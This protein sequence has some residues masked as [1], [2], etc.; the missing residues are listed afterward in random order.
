MAIQFTPDGSGLAVGDEQTV[1]IWDGKTGRERFRF[2]SGG[3]ARDITFD[4]DGRRLAAAVAVGKGFREALVQVWD[5]PAG[6]LC[7]VTPCAPAGWSA[8][9]FSPDGR[10]VTMTFLGPASAPGRWPAFVRVLEASTG[11]EVRTMPLREVGIGQ[12]LE[13]IEFSPDGR[14]LLVCHA[15][16]D[17]HAS[18]ATVYDF[19]TGRELIAL[20]SPPGKN[21]FSGFTPDGRG[22]V[23]GPIDVPSFRVWDISRRD[24]PSRLGAIPEQAGLQGLEFDATG[25]RVAAATLYHGVRVWDVQTGRE[26]C[27]WGPPFHELGPVR[28]SLDGKLLLAVG[29]LRGNRDP[30]CG[31]WVLYDV[32]RRRVAREGPEGGGFI[33]DT[34]LGPAGRWFVTGSEPIIGQPETSGELALWDTTTGERL[35]QVEETP[36]G[37]WSVVVVSSDGS[38][39]AAILRHPRADGTG[40]LRTLKVW[41]VPG[42]HLLYSRTIS[43][44]SLVPRVCFSRDG[45]RL[46]VGADAHPVLVLDADTGGE[47]LNCDDVGQPLGFS[48][49]GRQLAAVGQVDASRRAV[50]RV[51]D[52][53]SGVTTYAEEFANPLRLALAPEWS[54]LAFGEERSR[55]V[56]TRE[57]GGE[58]GYR[59]VQ[60]SGGFSFG[61]AFDAA[62]R[63]VVGQGTGRARAW[64]PQS[65][66]EILGIDPAVP[67]YTAFTAVSP[68]RQFEARVEGGEVRLRRLT[69]PR[70]GEIVRQSAEAVRHHLE[71]EEV[72]RRDGNAFAAAFHRRQSAAVPTEDPVLCRRRG[73]LLAQNGEWAL[74]LPSLE[75]AAKAAET[76]GP[77][78]Y[79]LARCQLAAGDSEG[80]RRS[81]AALLALGTDKSTQA[82]AFDIAW[83]C[84][85]RPDSVED[86]RQVIAL[87]DRKE[88]R[89]GLTLGQHQILGALYSRAGEARAALRHLDEARR[90]NGGRANTYVALCLAI[91][92][93]RAGDQR[94]GRRWLGVA[95]G[96]M[97]RFKPGLR[98]A[99]LVG[100]GA[101]G[102]LAAAPAST[103]DPPEALGRGDWGPRQ[104]LE[105]T[106]LRREAEAM[107][108]GALIHR[109][110][111]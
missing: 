44:Q 29:Q 98:A 6:R 103:V 94:E 41:D 26:V 10:L 75:H 17:W 99:A 11:Q 23:G 7:F 4:P 16:G 19:T 107:L 83:T 36:R 25:G 62:G 38:R 84:A 31:K 49:D 22:L 5:V 102:P 72:C 61:V 1:R 33:R 64:D 74:A 76:D 57:F 93:L 96:W 63:L 92:H 24:K 13:G 66:Q 27:A 37:E 28:L 81:C 78:C 95:T 32:V 50:F 88:W 18:S 71:E 20:N 30:W 47:L 54:R 79:W 3:R 53:A 106:L 43:E 8:P 85:L 73:L 65:G 46:A 101:R 69:A 15:P 45:R 60:R 91:A 87:V 59:L 80:F 12:S 21:H 110:R 39:L 51:F 70:T 48:P 89:S 108:R 111:L 35:W 55:D 67:P 56:A 86:W 82:W 90:L 2:N 14:Q 68:D 97:D 105:L 9:R 42:R 100:F 77:L 52:T 109:R 58:A 104:W 34:C 40:Y